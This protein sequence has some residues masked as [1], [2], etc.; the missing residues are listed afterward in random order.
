MIVA[1]V[2]CVLAHVLWVAVLPCCLDEMW[3][4]DAQS[5]DFAVT[6]AVVVTATV[7]PGVSVR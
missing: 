6:V 3:S 7:E 2:L 5:A 1:P 4:V